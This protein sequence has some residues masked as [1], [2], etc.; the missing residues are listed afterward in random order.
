M[1]KK[2]LIL[3]GDSV[4]V[5]NNPFYWWGISVFLIENCIGFL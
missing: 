5:V 1:Q 3:F 2:T 4:K